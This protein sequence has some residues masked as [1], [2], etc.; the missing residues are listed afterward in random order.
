[1]RKYDEA[2]PVLDT[3]VALEPDGIYVWAK[4]LAYLNQPDGAEKALQV[5]MEWEKA[6]GGASPGYYVSGPIGYGRIS[7]RILHDHYRERAREPIP[8][9]ATDSSGYFLAKAISYDLDGETVQAHAYYDSARAG[10]EA[11]IEASEAGSLPSIIY[12]ALAISLAGLGR[13]EEAIR[14][15]TR[16]V[17][18]TTPS[19]AAASGQGHIRAL[20]EV[21]VMVGEYDAAIE[22]LEYL[23]SVNCPLSVPQLRA[24]PIWDPLR[25]HPRFQALLEKYE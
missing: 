9:S 7:F 21:Y 17:E 14:E 22:R 18:L 2:I 13:A 24:D 25:D 15:A 1:M 8:S 16:A 3:Y 5:R 4:A 6:R 10:Y 23:M 12:S 19:D 20:A 11:R